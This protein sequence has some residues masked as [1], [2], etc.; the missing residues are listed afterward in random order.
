MPRRLNFLS[1]LVPALLAAFPASAGLLPDGFEGAKR[2]STRKAPVPNQELWNEYG[3]KDS[4]QAEYDRAGARFTITAWRFTDTTSA[5][6]AFQFLRPADA[7]PADLTKVAAITGA[8]TLAVFG[9]YLLQFDGTTPTDAD[10]LSQLMLSLPR[11]EQASFPV[12]TGFL[13]PAG[14]VANSERYIL[15]PASLA[16]FEPSVSPSLAAFSM[17]GEGQTARYKTPEGEMQLTLFSYPTPHIARARFDEFQK[18]PGVR[19]KRSGVLVALVA[20]AKNADSA[21][22]LLSKVNYE[23]NISLNAK[24]GEKDPGIGE[25][26][27]TG[28]ESAAIL[29]AFSVLAGFGFKGFRLLMNRIR[30]VKQGDL[31][32]EMTVLHL[33]GGQK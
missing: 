25:I 19:V 31:D 18:L 2:L 26:V 10:V 8:Q 1:L 7:K 22:L 20:S 27:V 24:T 11:L 29:F 30:G 3:F 4:D 5:F 13:P 17:G 15:G 6:A 21:E 12:L 14:L 28:L 23:A 32:G 16:L 33:G 9:N